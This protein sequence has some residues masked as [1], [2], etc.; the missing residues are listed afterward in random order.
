[1]TR[2]FFVVVYF[3]LL[4]SSTKKYLSLYDQEPEQRAPS[5]GLL[6]KPGSSPAV[7]CRDDV[8]KCYVTDGCPGSCFVGQ[9]CKPQF[10]QGHKHM[11][12]LKHMLIPAASN[13]LS[14]V[15]LLRIN[16]VL[17]AVF[18]G[19]CRQADNAQTLLTN[20]QVH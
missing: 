2:G 12:N 10:H 4:S 13:T 9:Y 20:E 7:C 18:E 11:T 14:A 19:I 6:C 1:M 3:M 17:S 15:N 16:F 8:T 5:P